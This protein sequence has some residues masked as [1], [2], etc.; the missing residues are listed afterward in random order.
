MFSSTLVK[1]D[2][3][4]C[5]STSIPVLKLN[6]VII[7]HILIVRKDNGL[8]PELNHLQIIRIVGDQNTT[9]K[10]YQE[11]FKHLNLKLFFITALFHSILFVLVKKY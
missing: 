1:A 7:N 9:L 8:V 2:N 11:A 10:L 6:Q 4:R 3:S 5:K